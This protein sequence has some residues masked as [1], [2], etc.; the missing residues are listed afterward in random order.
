[1][2]TA[3]TVFKSASWAALGENLAAYIGVSVASNGIAEAIYPTSFDSGYCG[4]GDSGNWLNGG[5]ALLYV[6]KY[7]T[8]VPAST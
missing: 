8:S 5:I 4:I 6:K 7:P 1:M 2:G 3:S